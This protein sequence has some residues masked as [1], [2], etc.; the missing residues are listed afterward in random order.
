MLFLPAPSTELKAPPVFAVKAFERPASEWIVSG[1][2]A[3]VGAADLLLLLTVPFSSLRGAEPTLLRPG[4]ELRFEYD[5][6][7]LVLSI[8]A[9]AG[10]TW[11]WPD[12]GYGLLFFILPM[13][14]FFDLKW[15][16]FFPPGASELLRFV[17]FFTHDAKGLRRV[18]RSGLC[19]AISGLAM[20][21]EVSWAIR[22]GLRGGCTRGSWLML[23]MRPIDL[24]VR[25]G[26]S[27]S[28]A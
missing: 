17:S 25:R 26:L 9:A 24:E 12:S 5:M 2:V 8:S 23:R 13:L 21:A 15:P 4:C 16:A 14:G 3:S 6:L 19:A 11:T 1:F 18:C 7:P 27:A 28:L 20:M 22:A 10:F